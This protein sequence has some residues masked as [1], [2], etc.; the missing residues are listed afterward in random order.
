[1][2]DDFIALRNE[3]TPSV[4]ATHDPD[5]AGPR[6]HRYRRVDAASRSRIGLPQVT[7]IFIT[8]SRNKKFIINFSFIRRREDRDVHGRR[9]GSCG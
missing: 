6:R 2:R 9:V 8:K 5:G 7:L 1:M 4:E 3:A